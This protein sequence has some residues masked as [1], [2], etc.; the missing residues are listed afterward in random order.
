L[1]LIKEKEQYFNLY[2]FAPVG[3]CK[4]SEKGLIIEANLT[5]AS[6]LERPQRELLQQPIT[7]FIYPEDQDIYYLSHKRLVDTQEQQNCELRLLTKHNTKLWIYIVS[8]INDVNKDNNETLLVLTDISDRK[9]YEDELNRIA[10]Y[11]ALT[12]LPN[13][14]L[15]TDRLYQAMAMSLRH[16][17]PLA[18]LYI[19]LDGFKEINDNHGHDFGD[20][21]LIQ[22]ANR[23]K[24]SIRL[25]D[26]I[27]R[28]GGDEFVGILLDLKSSEYAIP[29]ISELQKIINQ[30]IKI[31][32][33]TVQ[34]DASIGV[35]F[36][37][38]TF[39]S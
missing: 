31:A 16:K 9:V 4:L 35:S 11:D 1:A 29:K 5:A 15:L 24:K 36:F 37:P 19:D 26:T 7:N 30:P 14:T 27:S 2:N 34:I 25:E 33:L 38:D 39:K 21:V 32:D 17:Q 23:M 6:L 10:K 28:F 22:V 12:N 13:R 3:Y 18:V 20:Q 8:S